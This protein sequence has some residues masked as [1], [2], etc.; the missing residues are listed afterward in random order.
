[1]DATEE[2]AYPVVGFRIIKGPATGQELAVPPQPLILGRDTGVSALATD[3]QVSRRHAEVRTGADG[4]LTVTDL[5]SSNGTFVNGS[6]IS[7]PSPLAVGDQLTIG[8]TE[9]VLMLATELL[10]SSPQTARREPMSSTPPSSGPPAGTGMGWLAVGRQLYE[11]VD[12]AGS[13][14]AFAR[15]L[16]ESHDPA[17]AHY[18][19]GMVELAAGDLTAAEVEF[20]RAA[21]LDHLQGNPMFQLGVIAERRAD[22]PTARA[23]YRRTLDV[24]P[25]HRSAKV[26]LQELTLVHQTR[27]PRPAPPTNASAES[28]DGLAT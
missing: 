4:D 3:T 21:K 22:L 13:R 8:S 17:S 6:R 12:M 27:E 9:M 1:M 2:T 19:L 10:R 16:T 24:N 7:G 25:S 28:A 14:R 23:W 20:G 15:A 18:G 5:G 11:S 26:R